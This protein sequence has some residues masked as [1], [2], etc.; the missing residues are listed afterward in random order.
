MT[1]DEVQIRTLS[2]DWA[3]AVHTGDL[4]RVLRDHADDIVMFDVPPP[5][6]GVRGID[7]Y[8]EVMAAV[9]HLAGERG[10]VRDRGA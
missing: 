9:L 4:D 5:F 2:T 7:A 3:H 8:R 10:V 6:D 1:D